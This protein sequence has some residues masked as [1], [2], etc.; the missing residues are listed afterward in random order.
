M[1]F[2][3]SFGSWKSFVVCVR[4]LLSSRSGRDCQS[5]RGVVPLD[6]DGAGDDKYRAN[7]AN[8]GEETN[9]AVAIE[10]IATSNAANTDTLF[11]SKLNEANNEV[12][13]AA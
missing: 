10:M 2:D 12:W 7:A 6:W 11:I 13:V 8:G 4:L 9:T 1:R 3:G 5:N